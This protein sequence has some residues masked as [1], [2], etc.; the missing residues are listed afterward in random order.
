MKRIA[1]V[2]CLSLLVALS[3][4]AEE[5]APAGMPEMPKPTEQHAWLKHLV[6]EWEAKSEMYPP[7]TEEK[8]TGTGTEIVR[9]MGGFWVVADGTG[10]SMAMQY[11][12]H[13]VIG[14][15]AKE[16]KYIG[17][18]CDS[19]SDYLWKYEG[20]VDESGKILTLNT[21]GPCPMRGG[22][23]TDFREIITIVDADHKTFTSE[24]KLDGE[25][26]QIVKV[27]YTRKK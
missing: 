24:M 14:Y 23:M 17:T 2:L 16:K 5:A 21:E 20:S 7:G 26:Q 27:N 13:M 25:W 10:E 1:T 6:G 19:M 3:S 8:I 15:D 18:W 22:K 11:Q 12:S 4:R 9:D